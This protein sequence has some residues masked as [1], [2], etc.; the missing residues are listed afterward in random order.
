MAIVVVH[1]L[2]LT[3][4]AFGALRSTALMAYQTPLLLLFSPVVVGTLI[5]VTA[6][7]FWEATFG[8]DDAPGDQDGRQAGTALMV[9][10][11]FP[12]TLILNVILYLTR[13]TAPASAEG[14]R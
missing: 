12:I 9:I 4:A 11:A 2:V 1:I 10:F 14:A 7:L 8:P 13:R 6:P 3:L 5:Y